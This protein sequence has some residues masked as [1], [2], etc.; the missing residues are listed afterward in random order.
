MMA[1]SRAARCVFFFL[2]FILT[3]VDPF[4]DN[5]LC[6]EREREREW[7]SDRHPFFPSPL[8]HPPPPLCLYP[9]QCP[10]LPSMTSIF[11]P[12]S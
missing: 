2:F 7:Y 5:S 6:V 8:P 1:K 9:S 4:P 3:N 11:R 12:H 10:Y